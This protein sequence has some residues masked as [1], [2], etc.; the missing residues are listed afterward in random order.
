MNTSES[1]ALWALGEGAPGRAQGP[2]GDLPQVTPH[3]VLYVR[4]VLG[5]EA[6]LWFYF[7]VAFIGKEKKGKGVGGRGKG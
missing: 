1:L 3:E 6:S 2:R 5:M 4:M 7:Q